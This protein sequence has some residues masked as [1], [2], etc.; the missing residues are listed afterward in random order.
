MAD[1]SDILRKAA[2]AKFV[3]TIDLKNFFWQISL[4]PDCRMFTSFRTP[5]DS[6]EWCV[7]AQGLKN[8]P[9]TAQRSID[10][11]LRGSS[12]YASSM[13]DD[14]ICYSLDFDSHLIHLRDIQTRLSN[15]GLTANVAKCNFV[16]E[17]V[18]ILGHMLH[19]GEISPSDDKVEVI[20]NL[21]RPT[22]KSKLAAFLGL[23][24]YYRN[25]VKSFSDIA[26]SLTELLKKK[27]PDNIEPLWNESHEHAFNTLRQAL[28][29]KPVLRAPDPNRTYL[30][31]ADASIVTVGAN[32]GQIDDTGEE[33]VIGYM[34]QK[35]L[36]R[37][38]N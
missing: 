7:M 23:A 2:G 10:K 8:A 6:F 12:K 1:P 20:K 27:V 36:P 13:Q 18:Q 11:L 32:L 28:I 30:L 31:Q 24:N 14:I 33:Y 37:Q 29:S 22:K 3:S 5:W 25:H 17:R 16:C 21:K 38:R 34:S 26:I 9:I 4:T 15:A 19:N 35:L